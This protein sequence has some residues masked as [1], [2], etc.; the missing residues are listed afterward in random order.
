MARTTTTTQPSSDWQQRVQAALSEAGFHSTLPR[1]QMLEWIAAAE[2]PFAAEAL[3]GALEQQRCGTRATV[4]RFIDWLRSHEWLE[5][6]YSNDMHHT[7]VR[8]FPGHC[9]QAI[10]VKCG[11]SLVIT[12]CLLESLV[13]PELLAANFE[14]Y[15]HVLEFYG[16]CRSCRSGK[17]L[18]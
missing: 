16:V 1:R 7:Y 10:C 9:H 12:T 2:G 8:R 6:V 4:Y 18:A 14:L 3:V 5:R 15:G 13:V 11:A 17:E